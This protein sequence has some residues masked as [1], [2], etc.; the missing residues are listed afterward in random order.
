MIPFNNLRLII[1]FCC[2][3]CIPT[4]YYAQN[5][6]PKE[7][8]SIN[9]IEP[10]KPI[11]DKSL[12]YFAENKVARISVPVS[13]NVYM[14]L[15][16]INEEIGQV[17]D[18][19]S[20]TRSPYS[21]ISAYDNQINQPAL[22]QLLRKSCDNIYIFDKYINILDHD[23]ISPFGKEAA[24]NYIYT[25]GKDTMYQGKNCKIISFKG[26]GNDINT[27]TGRFFLSDSAD[28]QLLRNPT[29]ALEKEDFMLKN[30]YAPSFKITN[31]DLVLKGVVAN[32]LLKLSPTA[33]INFIDSL[34][35]EEEYQIN[36]IAPYE[37]SWS[38]SVQKV[39][40]QLNMNIAL[41]SKLFDLKRM[42]N[43]KPL[44]RIKLEQMKEFAIKN[45]E[46]LTLEE[47]KKLIEYGK[48]R[49]AEAQKN[50]STLDSIIQTKQF[51]QAKNL[52]Y[53]FATGMIPIGK[54]EIGNIY[55][56][57]Q[58]NPVQGD[59]LRLTIG[60]S[61][62]F[63][64]NWN[65]QANIAYGL[66]DKKWRFGG[67]VER[68]ML[69][70][71]NLWQIG[72][73]YQNDVYSNISTGNT[74]VIGDGMSNVEQTLNNTN[75]NN[76][77]KKNVNV[78]SLFT[79]SIDAERAS[80]FVKFNSAKKFTLESS[81]V[82]STICNDSLVLYTL[83][84]K[85]QPNSIGSPGG[86]KTIESG[87]AFRYAPSEEYLKGQFLKLK[88]KSG[89]A[90]VFTGSL[91]IGSRIPVFSP[92]YTL[93]AAYN[94]NFKL[95]H[96]TWLEAG[97]QLNA[98][99]GE[100]IHPILLLS[101]NVQATPIADP[102]IM[103]TIK[104]YEFRYDKYAQVFAAWHGRGYIFNKIPGLQALK[105]REV[106]EIKALYGKLDANDKYSIENI[107]EY[108]GK[109]YFEAGIG[110]EN[111]LKVLRLDC[112]SHVNIDGKTVFNRFIFKITG[113][114]SF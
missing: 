69:I 39:N 38:P 95:E 86:F 19:K 60:N 34:V 97:T 74:G 61:M 21:T 98:V 92:Y 1:I 7:I 85:G 25:V 66:D 113:S 26:N 65:L 64:E 52:I 62:N 12:L 29:N 2:F 40:V 99:F 59:R 13:E 70:K 77:T 36:N 24:K 55:N 80:F 105:L 32:C 68:K 4:A 18:K 45:T 94:Q 57:Y 58:W 73:K 44:L 53:T 102:F 100:N 101:P 107:N 23:L 5:N 71:D 15:L 108:N 90:P 49:A 14:D 109:P 110:F 89:Y 75:S 43:L 78:G 11:L 84:Q 79:T 16:F 6:T 114:F 63:L 35:I 54:I 112:Y 31:K 56:L 22:I 67:I 72:I 27:F 41:V 10:L 42:R 88:I 96:N 8:G 103:N 104:I 50:Q 93:K 83:L 81:T 47:E 30:N 91:Q 46:E 3:L 17:K 111:I 48:E 28:T 9:D 33:T 82:Y 87:I 20:N 37:Y 106:V 76:T 51:N